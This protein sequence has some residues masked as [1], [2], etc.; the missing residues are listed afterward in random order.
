MAYNAAVFD[1]DGNPLVTSAPFKKSVNSL[2]EAFKYAPPETLNYTVEDTVRDFCL[3]KTAMLVGFAS[4]IA[5]KGLLKDT[6]MTVKEIAEKTGFID[7]FY[8]SKCFKNYC[9]ITPSPYK[10]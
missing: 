5:E 7:Q 8:F 2:V 4:F 10:G 6:N 1:N 9:G 3:G